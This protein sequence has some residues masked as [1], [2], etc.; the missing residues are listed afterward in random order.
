MSIVLHGFGLGGGIAIGQAYILDKDL[1]DVAE[2]TLEENEIPNELARFEEALRATRKELEYLR[3]TIP[4]GAPAELGAFLSLN[5]MMLSDSQISQAPLDL[6]KRESCNAEWAIKLQADFLSKQFD[7]MDDEY[8]KERKS[9]VVQ[10]L[11]R[12]FKNLEGNRFDWEDGGKLERGILVTRDL[13]PADLVHFK[14]SNFAGFVTDFGSLTSHTAIV[15]RN[16]DIP[17]VVG[18]TNARNL[19]YDD[20]L[21]IIDGIQGVI[22]VNPDKLVL[23]EYKKRKKEWQE[24]RQKL[25][26]IRKEETVTKDGVKVELLANIE[27]P[28]DVEDAKY[29]HASGI[30]LFRSEF[31]FL[32]KDNHFATEEQQFEAYLQV[33]KS[34]KK[35]PVTIRT[36]D[37]G[38]DKNPS[39]NAIHGES[40][41]PALGLTGIRLSLAEQEFFRSQLRAILRASHYGQIKIMF[42]M[43]S[44]AWEL[45]QAIHQLD[46]AK[47]ELREENVPFDENIQVG[48]MIEVPAAAL[49][50]KG[51]L[52]QVDFISIGTN[53]L[54][55]YMLAIDRNDEAVNYLYDPLHPGVIKLL[56]HVIR[57]ANKANVPVSICGEMAGNVKLT[58][59]LL[60]IGLRKFS[61]YSSN[62]L[63]VKNV[64]LKSDVNE[65]SLIV[66]KILRTENRDRIYELLEDL[67]DGLNLY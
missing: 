25:R 56:T 2:F 36:A 47:E 45:N 11:E 65:I 29:N 64:I 50:I 12:I 63:N 3:S 66:S 34:M 42:P 38:A 32:R 62:I 22:I 23:A 9:D 55:Q 46:L 1:D 6:I 30:G 43:I 59:L 26:A 7:E 44:S 5:I 58:R 10:V 20:E 15:G 4:S 41:N 8:L 17:A 35:L 51:I 52:S 18:I 53:D 28:N 60:G 21:I 16:L 40:E 33:V 31:L 14:D 39:W 48:S 24:S 49:A 57:A 19:I 61:M 27:V 67:N 37:L 13:S 54:I